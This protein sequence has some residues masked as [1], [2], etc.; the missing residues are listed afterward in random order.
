[1]KTVLQDDE[2]KQCLNFD[3]YFPKLDHFT[4]KRHIDKLQGRFYS[5]FLKLFLLPFFFLFSFSLFHL[6]SSSRVVIHV[7]TSRAHVATKM[8]KS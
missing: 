5:T 1:M 7:R 2:V 8:M 3:Q 6:L 4:D